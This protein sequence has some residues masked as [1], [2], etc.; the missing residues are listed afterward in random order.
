MVSLF[1]G[2]LIAHLQLRH[3]ELTRTQVELHT[4]S[5]LLPVCAWCKKVRDD[6]GYW[7]QV[8]SYLE[9]RSKLKFTHCIC[10]DCLD[11]VKKEQIGAPIA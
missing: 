11:K 5:G 8:E 4:L 3:E 6:A 7:L 2:L 9:Q 10:V 1:V